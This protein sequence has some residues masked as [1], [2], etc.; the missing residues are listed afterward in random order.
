ML[1]GASLGSGG[2]GYSISHGV[3]QH[4]VTQCM[5]LSQQL[6]AAPAEENRS[7]FKKS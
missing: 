1:L 3:S 6:Q 2:G 4:L 5:Q 7:G